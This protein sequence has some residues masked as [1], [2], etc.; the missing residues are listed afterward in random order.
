MAKQGEFLGG[1]TKIMDIRTTTNRVGSTIVGTNTAN[2][3]III[4][5]RVP[6]SEI[7]NATA[8]LESIARFDFNQIANSERGELNRNLS[9]LGHRHTINIINSIMPRSLSSTVTGH[10]TSPRIDEVLY[11][12][13]LDTL[14][15]L[16]RN[17]YTV[18]GSAARKA[19]TTR[20]GTVTISYNYLWRP[21]N[22]VNY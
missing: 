19:Y 9:A 3:S 10:S 21:L 5:P 17:G 16:K 18:S 1:T 12:A 8:R 20:D 6:R 14:E 7:A 22:M 4:D 13:N 11:K 2:A 15:I